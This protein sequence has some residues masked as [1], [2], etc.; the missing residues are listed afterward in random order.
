MLTDI[1]IL[2]FILSYSYA[3][4]AGPCLQ[5]LFEEL[6]QPLP[7]SLETLF[8][9]GASDRSLSQASVKSDIPSY[10]PD[11]VFDFPRPSSD[12]SIR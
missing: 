9:P 5:Q 8:S 11:S 3:A 12:R 10:I 7:A 1:L 6:G 2:H 4:V